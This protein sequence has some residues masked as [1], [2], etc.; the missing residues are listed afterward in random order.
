MRYAWIALVVILL[1]QAT[2][3]LLPALPVSGVWQTG[4]GDLSLEIIQS[5]ASQGQPEATNDT[6]LVLLAALLGAYLFIT[7]WTSQFHFIATKAAIGLQ[8]TGG[9][10]TSQLIDVLF[11]GSVPGSLR[12]HLDS[13][14]FTLGVS[15]TA[16]LA[17]LVLLLLAL[18]RGS[19]KIQ[20]RVTLSPAKIAPLQF[21]ILPRGIDNIHIDVQLSPR[22]KKN[23][24]RLV[25]N[26]V[27]LVIQQLQQGKRQITPPQRQ[28]TAVQQEFSELLHG[29]LHRAKVTGEK[30]LP[31]L[32]F[33][34]TIK[35]THEEV[36]NCV[37]STLQKSKEGRKEHAIRG[38]KPKANDRLVSWLFRYRDHIIALSNSTLISAICGVQKENLKNGVKNYL[39]LDAVF[40]MQAIDTPL[41]LSESPTNELVQLEHYP[42]LGQQQDDENSF[43]NIDRQLADVFTDCL[44]LVESV[45]DSSKRELYYLQKGGDINSNTIYTLSQPSVLMNPANVT[46][47]LD[48]DW[49][50]EKLKNTRKIGELKKYRKMLQHRRFQRRLREKLLQQL[51]KSGLSSWIIATY[52]VKELLKNSGADAPAAQ[53]TSLLARKPGKAEFSQRVAAI[54]RGT[55]TPPSMEAV[56]AV[57]SDMQKKQSELLEKHLLAFTRDFAHY[58][59]GLL[60]LLIYQRAASEVTLLDNK[61]DIDTSRANFSLYAF[62]HQSEEQSANAPILS[63][64][65]IKAD[66]RGSTEVTEKLTELDLNPATHFD[67][68]FFSPI[69]A[70][71]ESYGAEKVFIEGDAIILILNDRGGA[72][73]E[74][75]IAARACGLSAKILQTVAKQ[76]R[77]LVA[78]GL[79]ELELGIG[80]AY[81]KGPPRYLFDSQHRIT[82][83]PAINRADR[84]SACNW[85]IRKWHRMH[86]KISDFVEVYQP[87]PNAMGHGEKAQKDMVFNLNGILIEENVFKRI[88]TELTPKRVT[89]PLTAIKESTLYAFQFPD[90][91][92]ATHSLVIRRAPLHFFDPECSVDNCQNVEKRF[93]YEVLHNRNVLDRLRKRH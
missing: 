88:T 47:L 72:N 80:I 76:N 33:I 4:V 56:S 16:L 38:L 43:V 55:S 65:I 52:E 67:R 41:V 42:I 21:N 63:H 5:K 2:K 19:A 89:N 36:N 77:E 34:A 39:G 24:V 12:I 15:D 13:S 62:L 64:I 35:L 82:I 91:S 74:R 83:S 66:L 6:S 22:F 54:F 73:Q 9:G 69:N 79:P 84:L 7:R 37:A 1:D 46:L 68:N 49:S 45:E 11:R 61:K 26:L 93:F 85:S 58:R 71:I 31:D 87:S 78:Y 32:L 92:G 44:S 18:L 57:W 81:H 51:K 10:L 30:Q 23:L 75:L 14:S 48:T 70:L 3:W 27:P 60:T 8:L 20:G 53:L 17:G 28:L 50:Q 86:G 25:H 90:L 59:S 29:A 40:S